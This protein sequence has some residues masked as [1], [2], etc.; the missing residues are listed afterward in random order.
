MR[1]GVLILLACLGC[2]RPAPAVRETSSSSKQS[3]TTPAVATT[4]AL[5]DSTLPTYQIVAEDSAYGAWGVSGYDISPSEFFIGSH[6]RHP[7]GLMVIWFDTAVRATEDH[8]V[9]HV[10][11][12]SLVVRDVR[13]GEYLGRFCFA[14]QSPASAIVGLVRDADT[15]FVP[16][17]AWEL[18]ATSFRIKPFPADSVRCRVADPLAGEA[19]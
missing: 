17:L 19:D 12:D 10:H 18:D 15:A 14:G 6:V 3:Q 4:Y 7:S 5:E 1:R 13:P 2:D 11:T 9:G 8:P 16:R